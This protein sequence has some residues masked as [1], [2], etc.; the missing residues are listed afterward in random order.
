MVNQTPIQRTYHYQN[1]II[2]A[3]ISTYLTFNGNCR[4]AMTFYHAALGGEITFQTI[5]ESPLS[6]QMPSEMK[7]YIVHSTLTKGSLT[8]MASDM[9]SEEGLLLGNTVSLMLNCT[10]EE[11][12]R[13]MYQNLAQGGQATHPLEITF[14]GAL[15]GGLTDAFGNRWLLNCDKNNS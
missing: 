9:V 13:R 12:I 3:Y 6:E 5:G 10:S 15:F 1:R 4:E 7:D 8:L 11:E 14:W 2:V